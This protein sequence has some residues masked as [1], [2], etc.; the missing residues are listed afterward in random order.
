LYT[1]L[2]VIGEGKRFPVTSFYVGTK[3]P[4]TS[5][6]SGLGTDETDFFASILLSKWIGDCTLHFNGGVAILGDPDQASRQED[7]F[8]YSAAFVYHTL[9][10]NFFVE[11]NKGLGIVPFET[12]TVVRGGIVYKTMSL[13]LDVGVSAAVDGI[14]EDYGVIGGLTYEFRLFD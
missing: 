11:V 5:N 7:V 10:T 2:R 8:T 3:L 6:E 9:R 12:P 1:K 13:S 4:N 14:G